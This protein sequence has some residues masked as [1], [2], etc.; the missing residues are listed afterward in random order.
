MPEPIHVLQ[1]E[2]SPTVVQ[3]T[4]SMLAEATGARIVLESVGRLAEGIQRLSR[5]GIDVVLLDLNLPDSEGLETF[6]VLH[7]AV[8]QVPVVVF[9]SVDDEEQSLQ[10]LRQGAA[11]YLV[12]SEVHAKWLA[13]ALT[14]A[15]NR[16][17]IPSRGSKAAKAGGEATER[18]MEIEKSDAVPGQFL[19]R[20]NDKR[21]VSVMTMEPIKNRLLNLVRRADST[22][23][24]IDLSHV[25]YIANAAIS[26]LLLVNK[27]ADA[28]NVALVLCNVSPQVFEQF[29][30]RRFDKVLRIERAIANR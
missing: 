1:I 17:P 4:R 13:R 20:I 29:S 3:L 9:T 7:E 21:M 16:T 2:D 27:K 6:R 22:E 24:R 15:P 26:T 23:V 25:E 11:D 30:S 18:A 5:G 19:V 14:L 8:P 28:A 10:A 12:K